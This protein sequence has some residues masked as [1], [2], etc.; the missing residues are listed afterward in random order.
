MSYQPLKISDEE[1]ADVLVSQY[2]DADLR[3]RYIKALRAELSLL[4]LCV[5]SSSP[6][7]PEQ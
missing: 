7:P 5:Q 2:G 4:R 6:V 1:T 3:W